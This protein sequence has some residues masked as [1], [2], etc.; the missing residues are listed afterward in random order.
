MLFGVSVVHSY[1][2]AEL[3]SPVWMYHR[4]FCSSPVHRHV[5]HCHFGVITNEI[6]VNICLCVAS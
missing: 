1:V 3:Y 6:A 4:L 5:G 2:T